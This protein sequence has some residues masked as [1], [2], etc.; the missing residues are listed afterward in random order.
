M[1]DL[2]IATYLTRKSYLTCEVGVTIAQSVTDRYRE[3]SFF[4]WYWNRYRK[5]LVPGKVS[6]PVPETFRTKKT[7]QYRKYFVPEKKYRYRSKF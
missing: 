3:F 1:K 7:Y 2:A 6:E 4:W 5:K